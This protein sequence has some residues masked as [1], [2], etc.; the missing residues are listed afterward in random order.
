MR[1]PKIRDASNVL[2][3]C[4]IPSPD[5]VLKDQIVKKRPKTITKKT[6]IIDIGAFI[7]YP[8]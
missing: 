5:S 1:I 4:G 3:V 6:T 8:Y 7:L 2:N